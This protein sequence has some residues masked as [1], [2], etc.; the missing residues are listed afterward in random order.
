MGMQAGMQAGV[1]MMDSL[2][3]TLGATASGF[4]LHKLELYNW[5]TFDSR[6]G[7][8]HTVRPDGATTLL[9]GQN[10]S[11]K[12]TVVDAILTLLVRPVVRNY[13]VAAGAHKQERDERTYIKGAFGRFSRDEDNRA[14]VQ[15]LRA[16][17]KQYSAI[18]AC[19]GNDNGDVFTV[20][21]VLYLASD[22]SPE[23]VYCLAGREMSISEH[24]A[25][26]VGTER[27]RQQLQKRGFRATTSYT[28][29]H[30]WFQRLTGV[31][32]KA[33][34]MFNQTVAV[35]DIQSLNRFIREHMLEA[36]PWRDKIESLQTHFAQLG[37]AHQ[38]LVRVRKQSILL[39]PV[40]D[41]GREYT[42]KAAALAK[43]ERLQAA[44]DLYFRQ[45][46]VDLFT[47]ACAAKEEELARL[48]QSK[49]Q[50]T[51]ALRARREDVR[52]LTNEI[53]QAGGDRLKQLPLLIE[54]EDQ[55]LRAKKNVWQVFCADLRCLG[56]GS[57]IHDAA[58]Y[59]AAMERLPALVARI[60]TRIADLNNGRDEW[61]VARARLNRQKEDDAGEL[62]SLTQR[63][64]NLPEG[65]SVI[66][67]R[68]CDDLRLPERDL[69]FAAELVAV[70]PEQREW[71]ASAEMVL[72]SFSLSL[73]V[74]IRHYAVVST[75]IDRT[76]LADARG[77]GQRLHYVKVGERSAPARNRPAI[78]A[79]SLL[80][81]LDLREGHPLLPWV[82]AEIED[83]FDLRCCDTIEEFQS[84]QGWA[85]TRQRHLKWRGD[86]HEKDD[87]E[88]TADPRN[89]VLGWDNRE[90][91][92]MLAEAIARLSAEIEG[93]DGQIADAH[94]ALDQLRAQQ[95]AAERVGQIIDFAAID[96]SAH[97]R[98]K[99]ALEREKKS[100]E[101]D[102]E[103]IRT[104]RDRVKEIEVECERL[105]ALRDA[106]ITAEERATHDRDAGRRLI[107]N[108]KTRLA[109]GRSDGSLARHQEA[110]E[111]ITTALGDQQIT[112]D[113]FVVVEQAFNAARADEVSRLRRQLTPMTNALIEAM[114]AYLRQFP[115]EQADLAG[116]VEYLKSFGSLHEQISKDDLPRHE[117][118]FKEHMNEKVIHEIG[119]LNGAFHNERTEL[120][121]KI[122]LLNQS[123]RQLEYRPGTFMRLEPREVRDR[124]I[125]EFRDALR[126]CLAGTFEGTLEADEARYIL[127]EKFLA[128][129]RNE[130]RWCEKVTDVRRW[131]D[132]A[133]REI[134]AQTGKERAYYED[135]TGQ[136]GGEKAKLAFTILVAAIAY[137]YDLDPTLSAGDKFRFVVV[138]EMF[139]KV[140]D[141]Y[142]E[143]AL[144]LFKKFGL[145]LLIVAPLDSKARVTEPHVGCY[146]H[147]V[148]DARTNC[149][150]I[151]SMTAREFDEA[152]VNTPP[153][154]ATAGAPA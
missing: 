5:G 64:G 123:P 29:Y 61:V 152:V 1:K 40:V 130:T 134:D 42:E 80:R 74:P 92:Q 133:A 38:S 46:T 72:H 27:V 108:A 125:V 43:T 12:S 67:R 65:L 71:Q 57:D 63:Q 109:A 75:Y 79:L 62:Q 103:T 118:R 20:A 100:L 89:F 148:K 6:E 30:G 99:A 31:R 154:S 44:A 126:Q 59:A 41:K 116:R 153:P 26:L 28:E 17:G 104:L 24:C 21:Q 60:S 3:P 13:N 150:E 111:D 2:F 101:D 78:H 129:L 48:A 50:H 19:F 141:Q 115:D 144:E 15:F 90:K 137:Q 122:D 39:G 9:I 36:K 114:N 85:M 106:T 140:D 138:D 81:K 10:G 52:R 105:Q 112:V 14:E 33:M 51:A 86:R 146:L 149:S 87:R 45:A 120:V 56:L 4:R 35:K 18:L 113:T 25:K 84:A 77:R 82:K 143:Y 94:Q 23:K 58:S 34:D 73:L 128:R 66:R 69:P 47:P 145:Q 97:A 142:S 102:N 110:F 55:F 32:P 8:V 139:S 68:L 11:G 124:E 132:F 53:E 151:F 117:A 147:V 96:F 98:E 76:R 70:N 107:N 88:R 121:S 95:V 135:S 37:D 16:D 7:H 49:Q 136:S 54:R 127:I 131:F 91:R 83:R 93:L 22:R 119:L